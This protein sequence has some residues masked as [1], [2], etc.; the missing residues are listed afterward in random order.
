LIEA[1]KQ[2]LKAVQ[3]RILEG[4]LACV[5]AHPAAHGFVRGRNCTTLVRPHTGQRC[6][7]R[8]DAKDFFASFR[9]ARV[10]R[11][12]LNLGYPEPVAVAFADLCT[13]STPR[14]VLE[15]G[16]GPSP[17]DA[18]AE[19]LRA[20][21]RLRHL[22]QGA[23]TSPALANLCA[24]SLDARLTGLAKKFGANYTRYADDL[25]FSGGEAFARDAHRCEVYAAAVLLEC[26]LDTAHRKTKVLRAGTSQGAAGLVMN[27]HPAIPRR[28]REQLEAILVNCARRG[29]AGQN[30]AGHPDFRA[31]LRGR[32]AHVA[33][34]HAAL[35]ERLAT[36]F[37]QIVW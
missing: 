25:L 32:I 11:V 28:D 5:P 19:S 13:A 29:V 26:G 17:G 20:K 4:V 34:V 16:L 8:M 6:V 21:L 35:G 24:F 18:A 14:R 36:L 12:F 2:R 15:R 10:L 3:R 27:V 9:R 7:L 33:S 22:P 37:E 31:H 1:P 30:R 23:P